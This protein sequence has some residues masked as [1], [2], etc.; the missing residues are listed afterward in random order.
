[1]MD[2]NKIA[3]AV[4]QLQEQAGQEVS[5]HPQRTVETLKDQLR[6]KYDNYEAPLMSLADYEALAKTQLMTELS[7]AKQ[8]RL[9]R[10]VEGLPDDDS[11]EQFWKNQRSFISKEKKISYPYDFETKS[12]DKA[13]P[14]GYAYEVEIKDFKQYMAFYQDTNQ[15]SIPSTLMGTIAEAQKR[16]LDYEQLADLYYQVIRDYFP[17]SV[18]TA[19]P[20]YQAKDSRALYMLLVDRCDPAAE[21]RAV[22]TARSKLTRKPAEA[23]FVPMEHLKS[24][25]L[26]II[27]LKRLDVNIKDCEL[28][29]QRLALRNLKDFCSKTTYQR[30]SAWA[31]QQLA[32][33]E[34]PGYQDNLEKVD[35]LE[36]QYPAERPSSNLHFT[37]GESADPLEVLSVNKVGTSGEGSRWTEDEDTEAEVNWTRERGSQSYR[38]GRGG[39]RFDRNER[40]RPYNRS[41]SESRERP[42]RREFQQ[43]GRNFS[44]DRRSQTTSRSG[45]DRRRA[46]VNSFERREETGRTPWNR[47][48]SGSR[49]WKRDSFRDGRR[50]SF[51]GSAPSSRDGSWGRPQSREA[52]FRKY[53]PGRP[54]SGFQGRGYR[55][56]SPREE[57]YSSRPDSRREDRSSYRSRFSTSPGQ[58]QAC[59]RCGSSQHMA[60]FCIRYR[61]RTEE[62]CDYCRKTKSLTLYHPEKYCL[63][64]FNSRYRSPSA[65]TR[66]M[67]INYLK[68]KGEANKTKNA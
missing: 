68:Q 28:K 14:L 3:R 26:Q 6:E 18:P 64:K 37:G 20:L 49:D 19:V 59:L 62:P 33:G 50:G 47:E 63:N 38:R 22:E 25:C 61:R 35:E 16:G 17:T 55:G 12:F 11:E 5:I 30:L 15:L 9:Q 44:R 67:R 8:R 53:S 51:Q 24:I 54:T 32:A 65:E 58:Q 21:L 23:I 48:R 52:G 66:Q 40:R 57:R 13:K 42:R 60:K 34:D 31:S 4:Q 1:M 36:R 45:E 46:R 10:V 27:S 43:R 2:L 29:A 56:Q 7:E 39:R 41:R